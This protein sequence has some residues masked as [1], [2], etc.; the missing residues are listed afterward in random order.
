MSP[1]STVHQLRA[2]GVFS[3]SWITWTASGNALAIDFLAISDA[4]DQNH[5]TIV[6]DLADEPVIAHAIF[7]ELS[8]PRAVQRLS[9]AARIVQLG[10]PLMKELQD[11]LAVLRVEFVEFPVNLGC[12]LNAVGHDVSRRPSAGWSALHRFGRVPARLQPDTCPRDPLSV[13]G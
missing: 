8:K 3:C 11:A 6:F 7:P 10:N 1:P 9:D 12:Q 13:R 5:Q 4:Q 2:V